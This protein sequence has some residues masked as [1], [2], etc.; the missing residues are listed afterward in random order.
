MQLLWCLFLDYPCTKK[1][2]A[3]PRFISVLI[4][5]AD[6]YR[7]HRVRNLKD[8]KTMKDLKS[9]LRR[10]RVLFPEQLLDSVL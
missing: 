8:F 3:L 6:V 1:L 9:R 2:I 4:I 7:M 5:T 10:C